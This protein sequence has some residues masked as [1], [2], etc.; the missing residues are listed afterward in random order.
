MTKVNKISV[1][2]I[3][4]LAAASILSCTKEEKVVTGANA[5]GFHCTDV[6]TKAMVSTSKDLQGDGFQVYAHGTFEGSGKIYTFSR[7]VTHSLDGWN[8]TDTEYWLPTC[9]YTFRAYFPASLKSLISEVSPTEYK[10]QGYEIASQYGKQ[11]DILMAEAAR[12]TAQALGGDGTTVPLTFRH[13]LS[14]LNVTLKVKQ[15]KREETVLDDDGNPVVDENGNPVTEMKW[16]NAIDA[17]VKAVAFTGVAQKADYNGAWT[18][19]TG[20]AS[21]GDNMQSPVRVTPE[22]VKIFGEDG[23]LA[24][25]ETLEDGDVSLYILADITLPN[26]TRMQKDWTLRVP[27]A[28]WAPN[29]KYNYTAT[30]TEDF[31]IEFEE[32]KVESWSQEQ[33][34]GTVI[35]R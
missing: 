16:V 8:Y 11:Q 21:V 28:T 35:I 31:N 32:P 1:M 29:N 4:A 33:M 23:L 3:A 34:S 18:N 27:A 5:I 6:W 15:V 7:H 13:L 2:L 30:L 24:I 20:Y 10:I 9:G 22:G 19:H 12:T 26:G 14:N 17:D 25:P